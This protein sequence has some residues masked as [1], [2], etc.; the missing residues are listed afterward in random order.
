MHR[1][2]R[3]EDVAAPEPRGVVTG[4]VGD[5]AA[6]LADHERTGGDVPRTEPQLEEAVEDRRP[7]S[8][9]GRGSRP[10]RAGD[11]RSA[12]SPLRRCEV[13]GQQVLAAER[14]AGRDDRLLG[15]AVADGDRPCRRG[16]RRRRRWPSTC[17]RR[18]RRRR[19]G[20]ARAR[21][22]RP[23][24]PSCDEPDRHTDGVEPVHV[25]SRCRRAGRRATPCRRA[26]RLPPRRGPGSPS[27]ASGSR[28]P[29]SRCRGRLRSPSRR[30]PWLAD[31]EQRA[32]MRGDDDTARSRG[33]ACRGEQ[34]VEIEIA[35][36]TARCRMPANSGVPAATMRRRTV[37]SVV[38]SGSP[39]ASSTV[40]PASRHARYPPR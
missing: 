6:G 1:R 30:V 13:A 39:F 28:A 23:G 37:G 34:R 38:T 26:R 32:E 19:R 36:E 3:G 31:V 12:G 29:R 5:D 24:G 40:A 10:R 2:R 11:P 7:R 22:R 17:G 20:T 27:R 14:E 35:H 18:C 9:T 21:R 15:R 4:P 33:R 8:S 25:S 16:T